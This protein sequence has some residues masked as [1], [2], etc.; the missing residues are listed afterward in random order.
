M[1]RKAVINSRSSRGQIKKFDWL[2]ALANESQPLS[3]SHTPA[4]LRLFLPAP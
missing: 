1:G 4:S 2:S 3:L